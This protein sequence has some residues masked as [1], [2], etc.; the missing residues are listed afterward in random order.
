MVCITTTMLFGFLSY[1]DLKANLE[2]QYKNE[3]EYILNQTLLNF[4]HNFSSVETFLGQLEQAL[5]L[6]DNH[7]ANSKEIAMLLH[8]YQDVSPSSGRIVYGLETGGYHQGSPGNFPFSYNPKEQ[9]W[10]NKAVENKGEVFWT[11]PYLDFVS[12]EIIIS[13][14]KTVT[15]SNDFLGVISLNFSLTE[16]SKTISKSK[17]GEDGFVLLLS[18]N[19]TILANRD[20]NLIGESLF[21]NQ[22][23]NLLQSTKENYVLYTINEKEYLLHSD[24]IEQNGVSLVSGID[25]TEINKNLW[26]NLFPILIAGIISLV[27]FSIITYLAILRG[28]KPLKTLGSLMVMVE[29]GNYN[30]RAKVKDYKEIMSLGQGFNNMLQAIKKRDRDLMISNEGLKAAEERL[31]KK[32]EEL[33]E[34]QKI[35]KASEE[36]VK[37]LA[38]S[39]FLTGL[40]NRRSLQDILENSIENKDDLKAV[41]FLD[42]DN[43]KTIN[44]SLGHTFGDKVIVEVAKRLEMITTPNK[45]VAR[46]SGDEFILLIHELNTLAEA[47]KIAEEIVSIFEYPIMVETKSLNISASIGVALYPIHAASA[48][49]LLKIADMAMYRAKGTGKNGFRI[50]DEG[51][52]HE[53]EEKLKIEMGIHKCLKKNEFEL[54][55]QPLFNT[56]EGRITQVEALLRTNS[57]ELADFNILQIIQA[58]EITGQIIE[59]DQWV[60]KTACLYIQKINRSIEKPISISIN[61]SPLHIMQQD[62]V[63]SIKAIIEQTGVNPKWIE[64]EITETSVM[65]S[66]DINKQ[67]L[68]ELKRIGISIHLD[69]FGTG[70]SSLSYLNSLPIDHLKIDKSFVD[71]MLHSEKESKIVETIINLAH[72]L[73]LQ[74]VA[75]GVEHKEQF[76]MLENYCCELIQGYYI[77]KPVNFEHIIKTL[78][79]YNKE[80]NLAKV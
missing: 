33:K 40:L 4:E 63:Q 39:D 38:S 9:I 5:I 2:K 60:V 19:G 27:L 12:Q 29:N 25:T 30:V 50:F 11:E 26:N 70:Y 80:N 58:A 69:D 49:E 71:A 10:Y 35:L 8:Q 37:H 48:E 34:S 18:P 31:R 41:I 76:D 67:K 79:Y 32:Y 13:A 16:M 74:V 56:K 51:M 54:F 53:V 61:I 47:E 77:S 52:V 17:I 44:D 36:K 21:G 15:N 57:S 7:E 75:E 46:I 43:F 45:D 23:S 59:I 24:I 64:L 62:F 22:L 66:F 3:S 72:N 42:L 14:A 55:F 73:G 78:R 28:V 65:K 20:N 1:R 68:E 6:L